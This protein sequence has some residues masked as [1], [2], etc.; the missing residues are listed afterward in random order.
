MNGNVLA[1]V[2]VALIGCGAVSEH[3]YAP[4]LGELEKAGLLQ[5]LVLVDPNVGQTERLKTCF[6]SAQV[7]KDLAGL[8]GSVIDLAIVAS[9]PRFH[10][11]QT[12]ALLRAGVSVLCEK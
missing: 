5:L 3:Y 9:P 10:A 1:P 6:P 12:I 7:Q 4:A 11:A 2:R 8:S